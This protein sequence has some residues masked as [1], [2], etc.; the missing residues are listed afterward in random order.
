MEAKAF[1]VLISNPL[2]LFS[3][4]YDLKLPELSF[5]R[6]RSGLFI[7]INDSSDQMIKSLNSGFNLTPE[8]IFSVVSELY[9]CSEVFLTE[10]P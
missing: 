3:T 10:Y 7:F 4:L 9:G 2:Y 6:K 8:L 5:F 1:F